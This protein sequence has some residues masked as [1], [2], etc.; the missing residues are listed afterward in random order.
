MSFIPLGTLRQMHRLTGRGTCIRCDGQSVD[1]VFRNGY[2]EAVDTE[3]RVPM[4]TLATA[5]VDRLGLDK[6][7]AR[8]EVDGK[9]YGI[10]RHEPEGTGVSRLILE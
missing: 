1:G 4:V 2:I 6:K 3:S 7:G 9:Q 5:E 10:R 8:L